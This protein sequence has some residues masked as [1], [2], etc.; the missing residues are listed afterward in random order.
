VKVQFFWDREG[1]WD[2]KTTCWIRV[3]Q[4]WAGAQ[5]GSMAIPRIGHEVVVS[6]LEGDPDR[7]LITGR[8]YHSENMPPYSLPEHKT[9][10][11]IKSK[12]QHGD[13]FNEL[14]FE[15]RKGLE[16][17]FL[18]AQ[19]DLDI[20]ALNDRREWIKGERHLTVERDK[21]EQINGT[22]SCQTDGDRIEA[23]ANKRTVTVGGD[24]AHQIGGSLHQKTEGNVF[25]EGATTGVLEMHQELTIKCSS[26]DLL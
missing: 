4:G 1:A 7:P 15:D 17:I 10:T 2:E 26:S 20:I 9:R 23:T 6:F 16:Q 18:H 24:E 25:I 3:S 19:R 22:N 8:V 12:T 5:Y 21:I 14:R 13:G 11:L